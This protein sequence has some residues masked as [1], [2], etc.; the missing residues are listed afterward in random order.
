MAQLSSSFCSAVKSVEADS[1][2][3]CVGA[4]STFCSKKFRRI[5]GARSCCRRDDIESPYESP[6]SNSRIAVLIG[7]D[8]TRAVI[9]FPLTFV[10]AVYSYVVSDTVRFGTGE[11]RLSTTDDAVDVDADA[12]VLGFAVFSVR[13]LNANGTVRCTVSDLAIPAGPADP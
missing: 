2:C 4:T 6:S 1:S 3:V 8:R 10:V 9:G 13:L 11:E 7:I 5:F 12:V